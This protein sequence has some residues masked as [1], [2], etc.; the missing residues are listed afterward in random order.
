MGVRSTQKTDLHP[1]E[2]CMR[3]LK[4]VH[5]SGAI[6]PGK[7]PVFLDVGLWCKCYQELQNEVRTE[8][9]FSI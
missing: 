8:R 5:A 1:F 4:A 7:L 9:G 3:G 2:R 6:A